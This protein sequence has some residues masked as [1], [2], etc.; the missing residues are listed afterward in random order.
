MERK[1]FITAFTSACVYQYN[2]ILYCKPCGIFSPGMFVVNI[3]AVYFTAVFKVQFNYD[4]YR[5]LGLTR[6]PNYVVA[7]YISVG[8]CESCRQA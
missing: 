5:P 3:L 7:M 6:N 2:I 1:F 4:I 8:T